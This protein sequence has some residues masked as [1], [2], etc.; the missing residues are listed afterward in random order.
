MVA[1]EENHNL[2]AMLG[3]TLENS[4]AEKRMAIVGGVRIAF[5]KA[6]LEHGFKLAVSFEE[7]IFISRIRRREYMRE[8]VFLA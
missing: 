5:G 3:H 8:Q 7:S 4:D 2:I 6:G 1:I